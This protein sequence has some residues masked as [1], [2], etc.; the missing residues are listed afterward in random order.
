MRLSCLVG[1][2]PGGLQVSEEDRLTSAKDTATAPVIDVTKHGFFKVGR[3]FF[4][5]FSG[6]DRWEGGAKLLHDG[7]AG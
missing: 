1:L 3:G 6:R 2:H 5:Y 7:G 4:L